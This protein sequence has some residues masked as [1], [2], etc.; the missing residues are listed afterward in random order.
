M[1]RDPSVPSLLEGLQGPFVR[2]RPFFCRNFR[3]SPCF[4]LRPA[5][6]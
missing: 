5:P 3:C 2:S 6:L 1:L 4:R